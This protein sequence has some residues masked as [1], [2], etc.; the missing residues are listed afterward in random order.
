MPRLL[1]R[2]TWLVCL[3]CPLLLQAAPDAKPDAVTPDGGRYYGPLLGGKLHG[4]G[5]MEWAG[6]ARYEGGFIEGQFSGKGVM[7]LVSGDVYEGEF[8]EGAMS[9][10]GVYRFKNGSIYTGAFRHD[11]F[12]GQGRFVASDG[13][14][15]EGEFKDG[16]FEGE[17]T[18]TQGDSEYRGQFVDWRYAGNGEVKYKGGDSYR[19]EFADGLY[20]GKGRM[21]KAG[22][23]VYEGDFVEGE[24]TGEGLY[25]H[26]AGVRH[27]GRFASWRPSGPGR[28]T[29]PEGNVFEGE[30][31]DGALQGDGRYRGKD[32][33]LYEGAFKA[34]RYHGQGRLLLANGEVYA[35]SFER[36]FYEGQ[37]TLTYAKPRADGRTEVSGMWRYGELAQKKEERKKSLAGLESALYRQ[38]EL[39][40]RALGSLQPSDPRRINMYYLGVAGDGTQEVFRREVE[41]VRDQFARSYDT[42]GRAITLINSRSTLEQ[43]PM[44]TVTSLRAALMAIAARMDREKDILF[45][46]LSSHGSKEHDFD[47]DQG[48]MNLQDL[49]AAELGALLKESGIRWKVIVVSA[50]YSGGFIDPIKDEYSLVITAARS[51]RRSFGC[52]DDND[53]TYFGEAFFKEALPRSAS[54]QE[55]FRSAERLV[56]ERELADLDRREPPAE[57][58]SLPQMHTAEPVE[59]YLQRWRA[60]LSRSN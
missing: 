7:H 31:V 50:C 32:G 37:G 25:T 54:F 55:A 58:F 53:F 17:G 18:L 27:E 13:Q 26:P 59:R 9:G 35:G 10:E 6:G 40:D 22:G 24:F 43:V 39:L 60:G 34:W 29:D 19:G 42:T 15:F 12:S 46:F 28:F 30:F 3:G 56:N 52:A 4:N 51:D 11:S 45:L 21:Q 14:I 33:S 41:Y 47:L 57:H 1:I 23:E 49:G 2:L 5:R 8:R 48:D 16:E 36:G 44:A 20:H 38:R